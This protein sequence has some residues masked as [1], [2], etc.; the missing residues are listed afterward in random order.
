MTMDEQR[1][2]TE[3]RKL[4]AAQKDDALAYMTSLARH[5][6]IEEASGRCDLKTHHETPSFK[7]GPEFTE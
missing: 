5:A 6:G 1:L 3:Y 2:L 7:E 4:S